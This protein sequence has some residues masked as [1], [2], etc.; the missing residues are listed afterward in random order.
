MSVEEIGGLQ[1]LFKKFD[2]NNSGTITF[3]ELKD[4]LARLGSV[5]SDNEIQVL[6]DAVSASSLLYYSNHS[7]SRK[8]NDIDFCHMMHLCSA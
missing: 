3:D 6:M 7:F 1:E 2:T 4:G 8:Y 5:L